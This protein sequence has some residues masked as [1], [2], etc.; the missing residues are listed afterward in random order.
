[1][2]VRQ[3]A[4]ANGSCGAR[5]AR[6]RS[7]AAHDPRVSGVAAEWQLPTDLEELLE[8]VFQR[9]DAAVGDWRIEL[10]GTDGHLR[11]WKRQEEGGR[12]LLARFDPESREQ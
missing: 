7:R 9:F 5:V 10:F 2:E 1:M 3:R 6:T 4:P 12:K 8:L 11:T